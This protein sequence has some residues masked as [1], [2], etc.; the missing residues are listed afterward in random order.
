[1]KLGR[2]TCFGASLVF[3]GLLPWVLALEPQDLQ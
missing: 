1:M 2:G 3:L